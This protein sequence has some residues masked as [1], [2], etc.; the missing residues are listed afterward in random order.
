MN[1]KLNTKHKNNERIKEFVIN[2]NLNDKQ[3][4]INLIR[5]TFLSFE[6]KLK[7]KCLLK[8]KLLNEFLVK[9]IMQKNICN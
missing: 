8:K 4:L 1:R 2:V 3:L 7:V 6:T 9:K 5:K